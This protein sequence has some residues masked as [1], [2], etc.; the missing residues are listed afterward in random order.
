MNTLLIILAV[1]TMSQQEPVNYT[2]RV[3][4]PT[5]RAFQVEAELPA[6]GQTTTISLPAW[7]PGH[8][9]LENYSRY[10]ARFEVADEGGRPL[11][12]EKLDKDTWSITSTGAAKIHVS[13]DFLTDTMNLSGSLL[14]DDFGFF[15]GTNLFVYPETGYDFP[16]RVKFKLPEGWKIATELGETADPTVYTAGDYHE[17]VDNPTFL[18]SFAMDSIAADGRWIRLA[19]YPAR[20]LRDPARALALESLQKIAESIHDMFEGEPPYD[21]YTTLIYL[22]EDILYLAGLEHANSHVDILPAVAFQQPR[23][24]FQAF[25]YHLL[26]HEYYHAWNVKRIRPAGLWPYA[27]DREQFTPLLWVS[28]GITDYYAQVVLARTGL[29]QEGAFWQG[30]QSAIERVE[31]EPAH[32]AVED[33]SLNTWID[34][35]FIPQDYYYDKGALLGLLLDILI[36]NATANRNSL[37]DVMRRLYSDHYLLDG[38]FTTAQFLE[39]VAE[40]IGAEVTEQFYRDYVD[41]R[42]PLP[43]EETLALAGMHYAADTLTE[44]FFGVAVSPVGSDGLR[45]TSVEPGTSASRAGLQRGDILKQVGEIFVTDQNWGTTFR[46]MYQGAGGERIEVVYVRDGEERTVLTQVGT[47]ERF[48]HRLEVNRGASDLATGIRQGIVK[49]GALR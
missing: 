15:N 5:A 34:P 42:R 10:V 24:A 26:S 3:E 33:A 35:Q 12:W 13:F 1:G 38:G 45:I 6:T 11:R 9:T 20:Y 17:L 28:E 22:A 40:Y 30:M 18:G 32:E 25:V 37:D 8:Y 21:R 49:G 47:R 29:W 39:Y 46:R 2:V 23:F 48:V 41:G 36:R 44:A 31:G 14:R 27:Y 19:V 7:T 4:D 16:A 43:F